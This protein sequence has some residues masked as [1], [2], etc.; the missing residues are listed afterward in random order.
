MLRILTRRGWHWMS[1]SR[2]SPS[3]AARAGRQW[4]EKPQMGRPKAQPPAGPRAPSR[5]ASPAANHAE[6][7]LTVPTGQARWA[8]APAVR[9]PTR[10]GRAAGHSPFGAVRSPPTV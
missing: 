2:S 1:S 5:P 10:A 8:L 4:G 7:R 6:R 9:S 3:V